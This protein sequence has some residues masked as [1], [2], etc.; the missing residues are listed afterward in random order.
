M[1]K[2]TEFTQV[3]AKLQSKITLTESGS[4][5][6]TSQ[7]VKDEGLR[8]YD[9]VTLYYDSDAKAVG[10]RFHSDPSYPHLLKVIKSKEYGVSVSATSFLNV[11][12]IDPAKYSDRYGWKKV[13]QEGI[14]TLYVIELKEHPVNN[15]SN[16]E[17]PSAPQGDTPQ[18]AV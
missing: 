17:L 8:P 5:G 4:F 3:R 11:N 13:E 1:Y 2:F 6:F 16:A 18:P 10:F 15:D 14:G 7:L 12:K 9:F